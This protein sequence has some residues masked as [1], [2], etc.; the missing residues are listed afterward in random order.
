MDNLFSPTNPI[1]GEQIRTE[2]EQQTFT[3]CL[4]HTLNNSKTKNN[5]NEINF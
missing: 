3:R 2:R 5:E 4:R 1:D